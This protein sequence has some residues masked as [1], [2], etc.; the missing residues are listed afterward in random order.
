MECLRACS[1]VSLGYREDKADLCSP[2]ATQL[3][4]PYEMPPSSH[5]TPH[6][7]S[8]TCGRATSQPLNHL[9][10]SRRSLQSFQE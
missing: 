9:A 10:C 4:P 1:S 5:Q 6:A 3:G 7:A 8:H 2:P